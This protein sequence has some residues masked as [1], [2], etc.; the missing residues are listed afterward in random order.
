MLTKDEARNVL[1]QENGAEKLFL[2]ADA[3][4]D[5][6]RALFVEEASRAACAFFVR[7]AKQKAYRERLL[8]DAGIMRA[9]VAALA[10][11]D[12]KMRKNA[13][14]LAGA[15]ADPSFAVPLTE[16]LSR[17]TQEYVRPSMLLAL[18]AMDEASAAKTLA[19]YRVAQ[20]SDK[21]ARAA[22]EALRRA[23]VQSAPPKAH[24]FRAL[25]RVYEM[26]LV[27]PHRFGSVLQDELES[28]G[29]TPFAASGDAVS[30][31]SGDLL[32]L[33][34]A[35]CFFELRFPL[36]L[37]LNLQANTIASAVKKPFLSLLTGVLAGDAPYGYRIEVRGENNRAA[38][39][40]A[41]VAA[42]ADENLVN[43]P[44]AYDAELRVEITRGRA[45]VYALLPCVKDPRFAYRKHTLPASIHPATAAAVL[46]YAFGAGQKGARVLDP[47]CGSGTMLFEREKLARPAALTGVD[48]AEK[49]VRLARENALVGKSAAQFV[50]MDLT[51]FVAH[52]KY[53]EVVANLPFGNRVGTH[54][55]NERLYARLV[56]LLPEWLAPNGTA[57]L[58]TMEFTLLKNLLRA[59]QDVL[60]LEK[61]TSTNA[62]GL[63]P[64][65][66][67]LKRK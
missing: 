13:A 39:I 18:G 42:L 55:K 45:N 23:R 21:H 9:A 19:S 41:L 38:L 33:Y 20:G 44:G 51:K 46:R 67:V 7:A 48:I 30:V 26:E 27:A 36:A 60:T 32:S 65:V 35:R 5:A 63:L 58:Y 47:C 31:R 3:A 12:P 37:D 25:D 49:S 16:A 10:S 11:E 53:D 14:R 1:A 28:L 57:L 59:R 17:E 8:A 2:Q 61:K 34:G 43:A 4:F 24:A 52:K 62:G 29:I 6:A 54:G 64:G 40:A 56:D 15:L 66:F 22:Q 50:H